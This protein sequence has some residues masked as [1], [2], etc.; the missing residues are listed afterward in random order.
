MTTPDKEREMSERKTWAELKAA[1]HAE[2]VRRGEEKAKRLM[3][4]MGERDVEYPNKPSGFTPIQLEHKSEPPMTDSCP[5]DG[6][7]YEWLKLA[8]VEATLAANDPEALTDSDAPDRAERRL[9]AYVEALTAERD[10]LQAEVERMQSLITDADGHISWCR[11]R[12][13]QSVHADQAENWERDMDEW[14]R[15]ARSL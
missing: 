13:R 7:E 8:Y 2:V 6:F 9:D 11:H 12:H 5:L 15:Q 3:A 10:R 4:E 1:T 14:I